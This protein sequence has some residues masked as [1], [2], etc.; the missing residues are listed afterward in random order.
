M[1][2]EYLLIFGIGIA[3]ATVIATM[4]TEIAEFVIDQVDQLIN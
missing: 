4:G 2:L 1:S 3:A